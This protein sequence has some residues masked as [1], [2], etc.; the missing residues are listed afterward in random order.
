M[1]GS[2]AVEQLSGAETGVPSP[3]RARAARARERDGIH[4]RHR[5][6]RG[7]KDV[8]LA[9]GADAAQQ[10]LPGGL[11]DEMKLSLVPVL[12]GAGEWLLEGAPGLV[13][14]KLAR[15]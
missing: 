13:H 12:L 5:W 6:D 10:Y 7:G 3:P 14:L 9:A 1:E 11:V 2:G 15:R 4:V 8:A